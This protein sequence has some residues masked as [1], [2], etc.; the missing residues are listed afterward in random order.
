MPHY[1]LA[2]DQGTTNSRAI[3]FDT[4][5][6]LISQH[7]ISLNQHF[8]KNGWVEQDADEMFSNTI[9]CCK[10]AMQNANLSTKS[11][12]AIG[13]T[14][15]RETTIIWNKHTG[16]T[17]Y[18]AI[19]WQDRRTSDICDTLAKLPIAKSIQEKT[20]LLLDPYFSATKIMWILS[21]VADARE[22]AIK[23]NLL[24]GTVDTY[25]LWHL[26]NGKIHATDASN[27]SRTLLFNIRTQQWDDEILK[28]FNIPSNILPNVCDNTANFGNTKKEIFGECIPITAM[29]GDQ[30]AATIGQA[31]F[32]EGMVKS[33]YG[34]GCFLMLNTGKKIIR[35]HNKLLSTILYR[36]NNETTYGL[37]GSIF[38]AGVAVK[39]LRDTLQ[40]ITS[41]AETESLAKSI[42][43][44]NGVYLVP[45]FTGLG[46]PYWDPKVRAALIGLTC[47]SN[48][49][50][51]VRAALESVA[52]QT[53]DLLQAMAA[54]YQ[55]PLT[56]LRVDGGMTKNNWLMQ[57]LANILNIKVQRPACVETTA[58]GV[59]Y[60]AGLQVGIFSSLEDI[61]AHWQLNDVYQ[62][63]MPMT[64]R[65]SLYFGWQK[66]VAGV[67]AA[68]SKNLA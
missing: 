45:A 30:Q 58:L 10:Q 32:N 18:P 44:T 59:A 54:D 6:T 57:F 40:L 51:I 35:S 43:D 49:A 55:H 48:R 25:L 19:V 65:E 38:S 26:T 23:G 64:K 22:Q 42:E 56:V 52:Y 33:T 37:E 36:I 60:L 34:T 9:T 50:H 21:H 17:I 31:C 2:I 68:T 63:D 67:F 1:L 61:A 62:P 20:G 13:I 5:G 4:K 47:N 15:Q 24:F 7:E 11:I 3:I 41:A 29:A 12:A 39:W 66:A 28:A 14:N 46:A 16:K 8:P 53:H 27:A